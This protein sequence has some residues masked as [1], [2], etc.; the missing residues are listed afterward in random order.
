MEHPAP[1]LRKV[2]EDYVTALCRA[3]TPEI[4]KLIRDEV[5]G[6]A[7]AVAQASGGFLGLGNKISRAEKKL[8]AEL[9]QVFDRI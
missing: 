2:W 9:E 3:T 6:R 4:A 1:E 8:M 5:M 7:R